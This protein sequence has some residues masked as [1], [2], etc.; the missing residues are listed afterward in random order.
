MTFAKQWQLL[1][2]FSVLLWQDLANRYIT[3]FSFSYV[4]RGTRGSACW[5]GFVEC[6]PWIPTLIPLAQNMNSW[7]FMPMLPF[8][9]SMDAIKST[10]RPPNSLPR[11]KTYHCSTMSVSLK[12]ALQV[13]GA[14]VLEIQDLAESVRNSK[15]LP[16]SHAS[17]L[18]LLYSRACFWI[19]SGSGVLMYLSLKYSIGIL[20]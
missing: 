19:P 14:W 2:H 17:D 13:P 10:I 4:T 9:P 16:R 11:M 8:I 6:F 15:D 12:V 5:N 18:A 1:F 3:L 20:A 7:N